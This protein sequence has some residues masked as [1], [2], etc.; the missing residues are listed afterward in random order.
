MAVEFTCPACEGTLRVGDGPAGRLVRCGGCMALLRVPKAPP[1]NP[2][3]TADDLPPDVPTELVP[4]AYPVGTHDPKPEPVT[5]HPRDSGRGEE[6]DEPLAAV[7]GKRFWVSVSLLAFTVGSCVCCGLAAVVVPD[8]EWQEFD[9]PQGGY[10]V[11]LP[12]VPRADMAKQVRTQRPQVKQTIEGTTLWT[13]AEHFVVAFRDVERP[14]GGKSDAQILEEEV[15][16]VTTDR[17][18][19]AVTRTEPVTVSGFPGREFEYRYTNDG[20]V[21]GRVVVADNRIYVLVAGGQFTRPGDENVRRFLDSFAITDPRLLA[22][23]EKRA[24]AQRP[25]KPPADDD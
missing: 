13:R 16:A 21:T 10:R 12:D 25:Q 4:V 17:K 15:K 19:R 11:E 23:A 20:T 2:A 9:S 3:E 6:D 18:I 5:V 7:R 8:P 24:A 22:I 1:F 14:R